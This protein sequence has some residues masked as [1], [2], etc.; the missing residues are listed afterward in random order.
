MSVKYFPLFFKVDCGMSP[1]AVLSVY[2]TVPLVMS[3][4]S[5][6]G[7]Y[8]SKTLGRAQTMVAVKLV[9]VCLLATMAYLKSWVDS[10][11][12]VIGPGEMG[13]GS[14]EAESGSG[15]KPVLGPPDQWRVVIVIAIYLVRTGLMNCTYPLEESVLMDYVPKST[16]ARWKAL[17]SV[18]MFGWC[19][20]AAL[21]G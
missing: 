13:S 8:V 21:G 10:S 19:G 18:S 9:G 14:V 5:G 20:S 4:M 6:I 11:R 7:T 17:D 16:R 15:S 2:L 3:I 12:P 1:I